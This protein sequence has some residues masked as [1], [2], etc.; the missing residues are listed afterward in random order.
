M[1]IDFVHCFDCRLPVTASG[2]NLL[3]APGPTSPEVIAKAC[4]M[5]SAARANEA[6]REEADGY[7]RTLRAKA[8]LRGQS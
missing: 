1:R 2:R 6:T 4:A 7:T 5:V 8:I 3:M